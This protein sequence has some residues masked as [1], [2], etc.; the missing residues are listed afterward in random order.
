MSAAHPRVCGARPSVRISA[1]LA[2]ADAAPPLLALQSHL[3]APLIRA[4]DCARP[5][6]FPRAAPS[7]RTRRRRCTRGCG[8]T[9]RP[10]GATSRAAT[11]SGCA[12]RVA[13]RKRG[14]TSRGG[15]RGR[16]W[17]TQAARAVAPAHSR[18]QAPPATQDDRWVRRQER[19]VY[20]VIRTHHEKEN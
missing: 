16:R 9:P 2:N 10:P 12:A 8:G 14:W 4:R 3:H 18:C 17:W 6:P 7:R 20:I 1:S 15:C 11:T 5:Q 19:G 13:E